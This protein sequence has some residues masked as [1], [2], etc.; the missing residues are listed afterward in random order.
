MHLNVEDIADKADMI[1][2]GYAFTRYK[3]YIR[4]INL[5]R[6]NHAAVIYNNKILCS[7]K[8]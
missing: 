6:T 5:N 2:N 3:D 1:I 4:I 8:K 7:K